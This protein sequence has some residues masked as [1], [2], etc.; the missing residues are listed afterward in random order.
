[1][2]KRYTVLDPEN[3]VVMQPEKKQLM[4]LSS[5][6]CC[7]NNYC[8]DRPA[9]GSSKS[10]ITLCDSYIIFIGGVG[11]TKLANLS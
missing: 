9:C 2:Y 5:M 6:K 1:M 3:E 8:T 11:S 10:F 7:R 4:T